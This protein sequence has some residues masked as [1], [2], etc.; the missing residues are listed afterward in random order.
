MR[1]VS[2][3]PSAT[4]I[5]CALGLADSL[6]GIS[7]ECDFPP[8]VRGKTVVT[9]SLLQKRD[10]AE[11]EDDDTVRSS[12]EIDTIVRDAL[13]RGESLYRIDLETLRALQP[14]LLLTQGLCDVCAVSHKAV[15]EAANALEGTA[16]VLDL[17]P[18]DL[19]GVLESIRQVG[20]ATNRVAE[21]EA[22]MRTMQ[23]RWNVVYEK[24]KEA[25]ERPRTLLL[26]WPEPPFSAGHWNPE[27]LALANAVAAP[28]DEISIPSRTLTADEIVQFAPEMLVLIACGMDVDQSLDAAYDLT[29]MTG[30]YNLPCVQN[31]EVYVADGNA[32]FNRPGPRLAESAEILAT[33]L[34]PD[35]FTDLLPANSVA[36]VDAEI[37]TPFEETDEEEESL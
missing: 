23:A 37:L 14:D 21:A 8:A 20:R 31:A 22:V 26:E 16:T 7:H 24:A 27:L 35:I 2:L 18:T 28:W 6:V 5:V 1:I 10:S 4:E 11:G 36:R 17:A 19:N 15:V 33:I 30:W 32:Y 29:E 9:S 3:L 25:P 13:A 12:K 34:H